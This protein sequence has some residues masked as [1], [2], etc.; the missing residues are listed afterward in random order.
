[1]NTAWV[2]VGGA[3]IG[4]AALLVTLDDRLFRGPQQI[5]REED[6]SI[7]E[8][9]RKVARRQIRNGILVG[10]V[11]IAVIGHGLYCLF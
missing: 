6:I 1:M 7:R 8:A 3:I 5:S 10:V 2:P 9:E 11:G 4:V